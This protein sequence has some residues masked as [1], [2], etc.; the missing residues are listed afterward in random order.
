MKSSLIILITLSVVFASV[1]KQFHDFQRTY[2][3][4][5][6]NQ[7]EYNHKLQIFKDNLA[8]AAKL[9]AENH[10]SAIFGVTQFS[11]L[12][13][14]EFAQQYLIDSSLIASDAK[15]DAK[16][17]FGG[18]NNALKCNPDEVNFDWS[19][20][21]A[22]SSHKNQGKC[23]GSWA[24]AAVEGLESSHALKSGAMT[25]LSAEQVIACN[26]EQ[27]TCSGSNIASA[28]QY[29][30]KS[31]G[32]VA[33]AAY[34]FASQ[35][36]VTAPCQVTP[37]A[38]TTGLRHTASSSAS[39]ASGSSA[40][41]GSASSA[42]GS[43]HSSGSSGKTTST[44]STSDS[45]STGSTSDTGSTGT[46]TDASTSGSTSGSST[47]G[48][49]TS[50]G[51]T[52]GDSSTGNYEDDFAIQV[53]KDPVAKL[54]NYQRLNGETGIYSQLSSVAGGPAVVAVDASAWALY[55]SGVITSCG[56]TANHYA[57]VV[58]YNHY[59]QQGAYWVVKNSWG[60]QWGENG[61]VYIAIGQDTCAISH[62]PIAI[63]ATN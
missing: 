38:A 24:I 58:G 32:V 37:A 30:Q 39:S 29:M 44:G 56:S 18:S 53:S 22:V 40:S 25:D 41:G 35:S 51:S 45:T 43:S 13:A 34:P 59:G 15:I 31:S 4:T 17:Q 42:S 10:G 47:S 7:A 8:I 3:R 55:I 6:K 2:H 36:G 12:T 52:S 54:A 23:S 50:E 60:S 63:E 16:T 27:S 1:N 21:G 62:S 20:C 61:N 14:E 11:D 19:S 28:L 48:G 5:Y 26:T 33:E 57:Q 46:S 49:Y 9:T